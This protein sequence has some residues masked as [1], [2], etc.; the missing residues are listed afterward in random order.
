MA[1]LNW[2]SLSITFHTVIIISH[3]VYPE[4]NKPLINLVQLVFQ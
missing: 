4:G 1:K 3:S 2:Q